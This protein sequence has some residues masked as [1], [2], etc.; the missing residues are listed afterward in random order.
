M[1]RFV[2]AV[3]DVT[4]NRSA[5]A[6]KFHASRPQYANSG[7]GTGVDTGA[8]RVK[9]SEKMIVFR[10]G[11]ASAQPNPMTVCLYRSSRSRDVIW[12]RSSRNSTCS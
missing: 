10:S 9:T 5:D 6:V 2:L 3:S 7:Y 8:T 4:A 1:T 12:I 11:V